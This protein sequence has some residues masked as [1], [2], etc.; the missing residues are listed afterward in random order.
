MQ[1]LTH[2]GNF[3]ICENVSGDFQR[4][5][6]P[7]FETREMPRTFGKERAASNAKPTAIF[8]GTYVGLIDG[9]QLNVTMA[10]SEGKC[11]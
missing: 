8:F 2:N 11:E 5:C 10:R 1:P 9:G 3:R 7:T 4:R 6:F